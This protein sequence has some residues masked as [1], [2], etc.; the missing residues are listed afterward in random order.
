MDLVCVHANKE[1]P[2]FSGHKPSWMGS[3]P[4]TSQPS[5]VVSLHRNCVCHTNQRARRVGPASTCPPSLAQVCSLGISRG[6]EPHCSLT[7]RRESVAPSFLEC[8]ECG[9]IHSR[10]VHTAGSHAH[11]FSRR[12]LGEGLTSCMSNKFPG[13]AA[14]LRT[15][16]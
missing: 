4:V 2:F 8:R 10:P 5:P 9:R 1:K 13:D 15:T 11:A 3:V 14:G 12:S 6:L 7:Q 16:L